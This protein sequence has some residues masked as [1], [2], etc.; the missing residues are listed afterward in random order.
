MKTKIF[1]TLLLI[2]GIL[3]ALGALGH[4]FGGVQQ[5]HGEFA[6][7]TIDPTIVLLVIVVWHFAG[8]A[9]VT[10]GMMVT[11]SWWQVRKGNKSFLSIPII[12]GTVYVLYGIGAVSYSGDSFF[13]VFIVLGALLL[14]SASILR[15]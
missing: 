7:L 10:F 2:T 15:K 14:I 13:Y 11:W 6:K 5:V 3:I 4:S 1:S 12:I 8:F 9:M